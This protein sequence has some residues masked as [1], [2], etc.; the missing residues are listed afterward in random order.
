MMDKK[1]KRTP[2]TEIFPP[3]DE[4]KEHLLPVRSQIAKFEE[5][6]R[7]NFN[8]G[9]PA[10]QPPGR[11]FVLPKIG[12]YQ[13]KSL[14]LSNYKD[15]DANK[16]DFQKLN[17]KNETVEEPMKYMIIGDKDTPITIHQSSDVIDTPPENE[18]FPRFGS[19]NPVYE[20][21]EPQT[22]TD[23]K[24]L[25]LDFEKTVKNPLFQEND[26]NVPSSPIM[27]ED[28]D[29]A[30]EP[31]TEEA[32]VKAVYKKRPAPPPPVSARSI[33]KEEEHPPPDYEPEPD[34]DDD[35]L[36]KEVGPPVRN[37]PR[38]QGS[39]VI[40]EYQG[41]DF[42]KY[43]HDS[44]DEDYHSDHMYTWRNKIKYKRKNAPNRTVSQHAEKKRDHHSKPKQSQM[45]S[46]GH[47]SA[48]KLPEDEMRRKTIR[49]FSYTDSKIGYDDRTVKSTTAAGRYM[50]RGKDRLP[51]QQVRSGSYEDFLR[52][53]Y[54]ES[55][56]NGSG[57]S[58]HETG[59]DFEL[60]PDIFLQ[61]QPRQFKN[62]SKQS[63][64]EKLTWRFK[65]HSKGYA[66]T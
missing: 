26:Q 58:G 66:M 51:L 18:F 61:S 45:K 36:P 16:T 24:D 47:S 14:L 62:G 17:D 64:W 42:S 31:G 43:M 37:F 30:D 12:N 2:V 57:D 46:N 39:E 7:L 5:K 25:V 65:R 1:D 60:N 6:A 29:M 54:N 56:S 38:R 52:S 53:R 8:K 41:E 28:I 49:D 44:E 40:R 55:G 50:K 4:S 35:V 15:K 63:V 3:Q 11:S 33:E 19:D 10:P 22:K 59:D 48:S 20:P 32:D 9:R 13:P 34:Y 21:E 27:S 23:E